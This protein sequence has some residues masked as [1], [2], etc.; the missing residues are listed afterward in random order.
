IKSSDTSPIS[1]L[2]YGDE[3]EDN[4]DILN[5]LRN[6]FSSKRADDLFNDLQQ[7]SS[8]S[9]GAIEVIKLT[10]I[11]S[12][13]KISRERSIEKNLFCR[14]F[15]GSIDKTWKII[16]YS[17]LVSE[18]EKEADLPDHDT[19]I[20]VQPGLVDIPY[21][22]SLV[23]EDNIFSFPKGAK[24][25]A[26]FHDLLEHLDFTYKES[27]Q[28]E[29]L[30]YEK[31]L[32]YG[33]ELKWKKTVCQ[34]IDNLLNTPLIENNT[35]LKL[36]FIES[37]DR[38]NEMEFYLPTN[39]IT[40]ESIIKLFYQFQG[41]DALKHFSSKL[42]KLTFAPG[43][44]F[45]KGYIDLVFHADDKFYIID[46]KSNFL[47]PRIEDYHSE[48]LINIMNQSFY[49]LQYYIYTL[50]LHQ[51]LKHRSSVYT[52]GKNFGGIFYIFLRGIDK[53]K[54]PTYGIYKDLPS[55]DLINH[56]G[57]MLFPKYY[58]V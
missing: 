29:K 28:H 39:K 22:H 23:E 15:Q 47:G 3:I 10:N 7:F 1:Y 42:E 20:S 37:K 8:R 51:Y 36:S 18:K 50:A 44:G 16:S 13:I 35:N 25:G 56:M 27:E 24:A 53:N 40:P 9:E 30:V 5:S 33:F 31:L 17:S 19:F 49:T 58:A 43:K 41:I 55:L 34:V 26:F 6:Y 2:L 57:K 12:T 11:K 4:T 48:S 32:S 21:E 14:K 52:Y 46:W 54:S 38:V 45:M